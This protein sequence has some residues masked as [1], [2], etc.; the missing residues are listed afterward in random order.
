SMIS[1]EESRNPTTWPVLRSG[2]GCIRVG[3]LTGEPIFPT[4]LMGEAA[5]QR[6]RPQVF[7]CSLPAIGKFAPTLL[8]KTALH[9][10]LRS[11]PTLLSP[12]CNITD[13]SFI[14]RRYRPTAVGELD[15][16]HPTGR[17]PMRF[18][19]YAAAATIAAAL[20]ITAAQAA[21]ISGAGA[22]FP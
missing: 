5:E 2:D 16:L 10:T 9:A 14:A 7:T 8:H 6:G 12:N 20:S 11:S 18:M 1:R 22:T 13:I 21:D 4:T 15:F 3:D 17:V 19:S